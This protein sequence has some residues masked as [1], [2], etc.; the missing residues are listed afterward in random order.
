MYATLHDAHISALTHV[1]EWLQVYAMNKSAAT[2]S[3]SLCQTYTTY[4]VQRL[5]QLKGT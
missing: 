4:G 2:I 1:K 3:L 5:L